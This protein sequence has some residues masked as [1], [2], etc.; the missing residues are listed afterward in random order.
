VCIVLLTGLGD[1]VHGLPVVNALKRFRPDLRITWVVEPMPAGIL[2]P[3]PAIDRVVLFYKRRGWRGVQ[4]L[5]SDLRN[6]PA[7]I[8]I[9]LNVYFKAVFPTVLSRA[10]LRIGFA[11]PL[12]RDLTWLFHNHH[13]RI[14]RRKHTQDLFLDFLHALNVPAEPL[15]W[16]LQITDKERVEQSVPRARAR[17]G[18]AVVAIAPTSANPKKDW[19]VERWS[20]L[21]DALHSEFGF[22]VVMIGGPGERETRVAHAI[23][24]GAEHPPTFALGD[25]V[26]RLIWL[27][28]SAGLV[29]APDT[30]PVHIAR[31]LGVPVIGLYGHTN[32]WRVG[33]YR[34]Y[35][36]L[37][38][39]R[40][41][42]PDAAPD[43][44]L[45]EP[46][47]SRMEQITV[48]D[49]LERVRRAIARYSVP[50][51]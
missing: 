13:V 40:Y 4:Q 1:V 26:R 43:A 42:E 41:N 16:R 24:E 17:A 5:A 3:H 50:A 18:P 32:P 37:W 14:A 11:P 51:R 49:V 33:P 22:Q 27:I 8:T 28:D 25:G 19:L 38:V 36:D 35:E 10:K 39:D 46:R 9:D 15:E 29:I 48:E 20:A 45:A 44:S 34:A 23:I 47:H 7:D 30:G 31:A 6:D 12:A 21:S 2:Q